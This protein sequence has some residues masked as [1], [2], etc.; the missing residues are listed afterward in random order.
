M[1]GS[2]ETYIADLYFEAFK[3]TDSEKSLKT[4]QSCSQSFKSI[5]QGINSG[6]SLIADQLKHDAL[7]NEYYL[8]FDRILKLKENHPDVKF[9]L[10]VEN[11]SYALDDQMRIVLA[12]FFYMAP[13]FKDVFNDDCLFGGC[14]A[15]EWLKFMLK[16]ATLK[17]HWSTYSAFIGTFPV[18]ITYRQKECSFIERSWFKTAKPRDYMRDETLAAKFDEDLF[19][20]MVSYKSKQYGKQNM[21]N[22]C[23]IAN[24]TKYINA[25]LAERYCETMILALKDAY[26]NA[27][28][29]LVNQ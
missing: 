15:N 23:R 13:Q 6:L 14:P 19:N 22:Y 1:T 18:T 5:A 8:V 29:E 10:R 2:S 20:S 28:L 26:S 11:N 24:G 7:T 16:N 4:L 17:L 9:E 3:P 25:W 21:A 27:V 12:W